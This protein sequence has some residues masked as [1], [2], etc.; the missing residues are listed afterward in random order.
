MPTYAAIV[1]RFTSTLSAW[2][3]S[4]YACQV[5]TN[6]LV[7]DADDHGDLGVDRQRHQRHGQQCETEAG[8]DLQERSDEDG[9]TNDDQ[10]GGGH[11]HRF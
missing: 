6:T 10:L 11:E 9:R 4:L 3:R 1:I 8:N 2:A 7:S 5:V